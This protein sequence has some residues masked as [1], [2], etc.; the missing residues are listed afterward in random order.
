[1][2][3]E[4][5]LLTREWQDTADKIQFCY[6]IATDLGPRQLVL[7]GQQAVFF[8]A[9]SDQHRVE[10]LLG[11]Q[12]A[13][14]T[15]IKLKRHDGE[16]VSACY[17]DSLAYY[18]RARRLLESAQVAIQEA[19]VRAVDRFMMERFI[20][21]GVSVDGSCTNDCY[22]NPKL[23]ASN[24]RPPL[25]WAS[26]DI[27]TDPTASQLFSIGV[28]SPAD[29]VVWVIGGQDADRASYRLVGVA[30]ETACLNALFD[31][32]ALHDPDA[33]IGWNLVG[34]DIYQL[35]RYCDRLGIACRLGRW[36][37]LPS[38]REVNG[39]HY[40]QIPG[41]VCLD[42]IELLKL[43][44]HQFTN[45]KL[46]VVG[47]ELLGRTKLLDGPEEILDRYH[48]NK[49]EL[50]D[51]NFVDCELVALIFAKTDLFNFAIERSQLTGLVL[52]KVGG[53]AAAFDYLYLP[54][55]HRAGYVAP[56]FGQIQTSIVSPGGYVMNSKPG[57][58]NHVLVLDFKSLYP[59]IIRTF[60]V[61]PVAHWVWQNGPQ[62]GLDQSGDHDQ[63]VGPV[64]GFDGASFD[65]SSAVLP[66][67]IKRLSQAREQAKADNNQPLSLAIKIIMNSFY[68]VLG[69]PGCR[70]FDPR[71]AS[72]I[73]RRGH[74]IIQTTTQWIEALG[75][76]VIY[77]DTD[78]VFVYLKDDQLSNEQVL[79]I[80]NQLQAALNVQWSD[81]LQETMG[82]KSFLELEF[83]T[84]F[85]RFLMPRI[86][87][88]E[89]GSKKRYA[90]IN[91]SN[92]LIVKGMESVRSDWSK[93]A[94]SLQ[95]KLFVKLF[96]GEPIDDLLRD[97]VAA[98]TEGRVDD[99]LIYR[100]RLRRPVE[101]F[102]KST[103]PHIKALREAQKQDATVVIELGD[104]IEY[105]MTTKGPQLV[106]HQ[107]AP[108][109]YQHY[110]DRQI[111]PVAEPVL[112]CLNRQF[113]DFLPIQQSRL[114]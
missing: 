6:T 73:T 46:G 88:S 42:G 94:G 61:D 21:G 101:S 76:D 70:F 113:E 63:A 51:Y 43:G 47:E 74:Q 65:A 31:W 34:F 83:E 106:T 55:M 53:S 30:D 7:S 11:T 85:T 24:Y 41:R 45:F 19:D 4:G 69:S 28:A 96:N 78:S 60:S 40:V 89:E 112:D 103:P 98:I 20:T 29:N 68:G 79:E 2:P 111:A 1:M 48:N 9:Q 87:G 67:L 59:S 84:H 90:G 64:E 91:P 8:V 27:E 18:Q 92:K 50:A 26:V 114:F 13:K 17:F 36:A 39:R 81:Y 58:Y 33:L 44:G 102:V 12:L 109:D 38:W 10:R 72:S 37:R 14:A 66:A 16:P 110:L 75:Y 15:P 105:L 77:G 35:Q 25:R 100:V 71:L 57:L 108:I 82:V 22:S 56:D 93:F 104:S 32:L 49:V 99:Q 3:C 97:A 54:H 86:R 80:G 95:N 23:R 62:E 5:F 52:D 107:L